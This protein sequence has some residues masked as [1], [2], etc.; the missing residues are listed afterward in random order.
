[1]LALA[2]Y[3]DRLSVRP[4][5]T[6][7][8]KV[9]NA[10]DQPVTARIVRVISSDANPAG[11]GIQVEEVDA[12]ITTLAEPGPERVPHGSYAVVS[13]LAPWQSG[14]SFT[15]CCRAFPTL[16]DGRRQGLITRLSETRNLG[17]G[18]MI[19]ADGRLLGTMGNGGGFEEVRTPTPLR[20]RR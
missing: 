10:T 11:P 5:E 16:L 17:V 12:D 20:E 2:A 8:F 6:V 9:A 19:D 4:G 3:A 13:G 15:L 1:M 18:L 7:D 14:N